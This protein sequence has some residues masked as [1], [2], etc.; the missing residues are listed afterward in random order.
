MEIISVEEVGSWING[1]DSSNASLTQG[2]A[3][4]TAL[5]SSLTVGGYAKR[6][7]Q[8]EVR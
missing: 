8:S 7:D 2:N 1:T 6:N 5:S 3:I 4:H